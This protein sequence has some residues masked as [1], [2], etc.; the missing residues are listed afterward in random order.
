MPCYNGCTRQ[1]RTATTP[2]PAPMTPQRYDAAIIG[3]GIVGCAAAFYL[4]RRGLKVVVLEKGEIAGEQSGRNWGFVRQQGRDPRELPLMIECNRMWR[5]LPGVLE[6]DIEWRQGGLLYLARDEAQLAK[7]EAWLD[8]ARNHRIDSRLLSGAEAAAMIPGLRG[9]WCGALYTP[10]DGHADPLKTTRAFAAAARRHGADVRTGCVVEAIETAGGG[11]CGVRTEAGPIAAATVLV[12]AGAWTSRFL[13]PLLRPLGLDL[14]QLYVRATVL[15]TTA[16]PPALPFGVWS[17]DIGFR[18]RRDGTFNVAPGRSSDFYV[19]PDLV[20]YLR[21]FWPAYRRE[22]GDARPYFSRETVDG[23]AHLVG[24]QPALVRQMKRHRVFAPPPNRT[25]AERA[26]TAF[27]RLLPAFA[28]LEM[29]EAWAGAIEVTPDEVPVLDA[30]PGVRNLVVA[31][32]FSGHGFGFG[33][34][35]GRVMAE[36][37]A[38]GQPSF[39]LHAFRFTR[40]AEAGHSHDHDAV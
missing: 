21:P 26:L 31:T 35:A 36:M 39:D 29:R 2:H 13:R 1:N 12:A 19:V 6:A 24:G 7:Y 9:T 34:I 23:L 20:R 22:R 8:H 18:Q 10:S 33:P 28:G 38:D 4:A 32:G 30:V 16:A 27:K 25:A 40:F 15:R 14:P 37:I 17:G 3:G 11:A 5:D